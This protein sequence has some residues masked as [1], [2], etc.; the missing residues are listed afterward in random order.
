MHW[1]VFS[2]LNAFFVSLSQALGKR[3]QSKLDTLS[4][5]WAQT[6][7]SLFLLFPLALFTNAFQPVTQIFWQALFVTSI[8]NTAT[9]I[10]MMIALKDAPLS[11]TA[12]IATLTPVFLLIT[13]PLILGE[14]PTPLG[15]VGILITVFGSYV[16]NLSKRSQGLLHPFISIATE[17]G[18]REMLL[19]AFLWSITSNL[20]KVAVTES[21]PI[22]YIFSL[23]F[24]IL[25]FLTII[26][27]IRKVSF[28]NIFKNTKVLAP[29]GICLGLSGIFQM[30]AISMTIVPNVIALKRTS[31]VFSVVWG[32]LL[33]QEKDI[34]ERIIGS[35][36]MVLGVVFIIAS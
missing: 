4:V 10:L 18:P 29:V 20:D 5:T 15:V 17:K 8:L 26:L 19:V 11:L 36:I 31:A 30:I 35:A 1:L 6:F 7:F 22:M 28:A 23:T 33:F 14:F 24:S 13:S 21:N 16:L 2:I 9:A 25:C 32:K 27:L 3:A 34:K 12:P